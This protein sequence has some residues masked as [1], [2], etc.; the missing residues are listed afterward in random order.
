MRSCVYCL[1]NDDYRDRVWRKKDIEIL[2][3]DINGMA[4]IGICPIPATDDIT[5]VKNVAMSEHTLTKVL[6]D[7][8]PNNV[9]IRKNILNYYGSQKDPNHATV[10]DVMELMRSG[11]EKDKLV[12]YEDELYVLGIYKPDWFEYVNCH[13]H[14]IACI[15]SEAIGFKILPEGKEVIYIDKCGYVSDGKFIEPDIFYGN[16]VEF[17][18]IND[19]LAIKVDSPFNLIGKIDL[20]EFVE[21]KQPN[22]AWLKSICHKLNISENVD[23][24]MDVAVNMDVAINKVYETLN[25][26]AETVKINRP[27]LLLGQKYVEALQIPTA[28]IKNIQSAEAIGYVARRNGNVIVSGNPLFTGRTLEDGAIW[29]L[30]ELK[31]D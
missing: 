9:S 28:K 24:N 16:L 27:L 4:G 18:P 15:K 6:Y 12:S 5:Y 23:P 19:S 11:A 14:T 7:V 8:L 13:G 31:T 20:T 22:R 21:P 1:I 25:N 26:I 2:D 29:Y 3:S 10:Q 30:A 17:N